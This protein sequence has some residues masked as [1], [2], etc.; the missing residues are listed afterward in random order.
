[1]SDIGVRDD[2]QYKADFPLDFRRNVRGCF[3]HNDKNKEI[4]ILFVHRLPDNGTC[5]GSVY[6][7]KGWVKGDGSIWKLESLEPLTLSPSILCSCQFHGF[8]VGGVWEFASGSPYQEL[9][10][11]GA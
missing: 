6:W 9:H 1:M 7:E 8:I 4:G 2:N 3:L 10:P 11:P 5:G